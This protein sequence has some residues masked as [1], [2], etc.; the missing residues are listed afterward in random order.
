[1]GPLSRA[2]DKAALDKSYGSR[3]EHDDSPTSSKD[4]KLVW[5][6]DIIG[7]EGSVKFIEVFEED[8][9]TDASIGTKL[10]IKV[11]Y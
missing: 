6:G 10:I 2:R 3:E 11:R 8:K 5:Y 1:M 9:E 4:V 7:R